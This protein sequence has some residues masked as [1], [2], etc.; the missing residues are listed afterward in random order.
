MEA[1]CR[2]PPVG[3]FARTE[4]QLASSDLPEAIGA[5]V[6][7]LRGALAPERVARGLLDYKVGAPGSTCHE[8]RIE[9]K[10]H[11]HR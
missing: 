2:K 9:I 3:T 11:A 7:R 4:R 10:C 6:S 8:D 1:V 5:F